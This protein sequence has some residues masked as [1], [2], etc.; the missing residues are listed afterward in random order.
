[1]LFA[2]TELLLRCLEALRLL[3]LRSHGSESICPSAGME[4]G[5]RCNHGHI[6]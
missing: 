2:C 4:N 5:P 6:A 1:M 3:D